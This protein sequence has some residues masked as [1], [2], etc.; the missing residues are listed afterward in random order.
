[1]YDGFGKGGL[2]GGYGGGACGGDGF[3]L[4]GLFGGFGGSGG[5]GGSSGTGDFRC[6]FRSL[7]AG[8]AKNSFH[9]AQ[10][11]EV[12]TVRMQQVVMVLVRSFR[13]GLA[14]LLCTFGVGLVHLTG[15]SVQ[16]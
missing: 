1:L 10:G 16:E 11:V 14:L 7:L 2:F 15:Q 8:F 6:R 13:V 3:G 9:H 5:S 4:G 12:V